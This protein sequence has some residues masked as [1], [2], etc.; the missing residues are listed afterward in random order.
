MM[1]SK[2]SLFICLGLAVLLRLGLFLLTTTL[3]PQGKFENDSYW[4]VE[5]GDSIAREGRFVLLNDDGKTTRY[6]MYRTPGYPF[7][8]AV[9][10]GRLKWPLDQVLLVQIAL[11]IAAARMVYGTAGR[12]DP[13]AAVLA[14]AIIAFDP[15]ITVS[16]LMLMTETV[17]LFL[18]ALFL[19]LFIRYREST[20]LRLII[21]IALT[22]AAA[23]YVRPIGYFLGAATALFMIYDRS[24]GP[25][26]AIVHAIV[27]LTVVY[28]LLGLW[29]ARNYRRNGNSAFSTVTGATDK[30]GLYKSYARDGKARRTASPSA[31]YINCGSRAVLALFTRPESFKFWKMKPLTVAG[32]IVSYPWIVFWMSG[33]LVGLGKTGSDRRFHFLVWIILYFAVIK[34]AGTMLFESARFRV[35][36]MPF[37]AVIAASGWKAIRAQKS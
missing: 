10:H 20:T 29:Q 6:E 21:A 32:K 34:V 13:D 16:S 7:F 31:Y 18:M 4:Y 23:A 15:A 5:G 8:L 9:L 35:P 37:I 30:D 26:K 1:S 22:I 24:G 17:F 11:T 12:I 36:M 2:R 28:S 27:L 3:A 25:K 14:A 33:F 19:C